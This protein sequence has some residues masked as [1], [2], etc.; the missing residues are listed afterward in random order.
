[1]L[2]DARKVREIADYDIQE[3]IIEPTASLKIEEGKSFLP[4]IKKISWEPVAIGC[5]IK[6]CFVGFTHIALKGKPVSEWHGLEGHLKGTAE[7]TASLRRSSVAPIGDG[8]RGCG[9]IWG[10]I[11]RISR[12]CFLPL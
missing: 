8:L 10:S 2:I 7:L 1:M 5:L 12:K 9:M 11:R 3:E 4:A 6:I